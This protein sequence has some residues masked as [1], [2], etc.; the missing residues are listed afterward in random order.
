MVTR[1]IVYDKEKLTIKKLPQGLFPPSNKLLQ[2]KHCSIIL[3][4]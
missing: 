4:S 1:F 3:E 2:T